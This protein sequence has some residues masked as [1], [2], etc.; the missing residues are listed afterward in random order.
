MWYVIQVKSGNEE[1]IVSQ[2][3]KVID[4]DTLAKCFIPYYKQMRKYGGEWHEEKKILFPGYVFL[5]SEKVEELCFQLKSIMGLTKMVG[6]GDDIVPLDIEEVEFLKSFGREAQV[7]EVSHGLIENDE[8]HI[9]EGP[10]KGMEGSIKRIDRHKRIAFL[11]IEMMGRKVETKVG[12]EI[13]S[14]R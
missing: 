12:L 5:I 6:V 2:C 3:Q 4:T 8:I 10:L 11:E 13:V 7:V 1:N 9:I 14:R